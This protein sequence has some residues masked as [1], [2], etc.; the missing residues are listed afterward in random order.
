LDAS[1]AATT[2]TKVSSI[3]HDNN[4]SRDNSFVQVDADTFALAYAG[5]NL[6]GFITTFD[7]S[8]DGTTITEVSSMILIGV[9]TTLLYR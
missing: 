3:E 9:I 6:D 1:I 4:K 5:L 2:V 8:A 7:I